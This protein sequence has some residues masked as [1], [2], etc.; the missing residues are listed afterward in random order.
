MDGLNRRAMENSGTHPAGRSGAWT[1]GVVAHG[2]DRRKVLNGVLWIFCEPERIMARLA[3]AIWTIPDRTPALPKLG[4]AR[5]HGASAADAGPTPQG[6]RRIGFERMFCGRDTRFVPAKRGSDKWGNT[7]RGKGARSWALQTAMVFLSPCGQ[8]ARSPAEVKLVAA[9]LEERIVAEVP[10]RLIG[11]KAYDSDRL[12]EQLMQEYGTEN[13]CTQ[14]S[15]PARVPTQDG[16]SLR[17]Y[18][19]RYKI[20][21]LFVRLFQ[22]PP[23]GGALRI[24]CGEFSRG[25]GPSG[26]GSY[27]PQAFTDASLVIFREKNRGLRD[28]ERN[29]S[30]NRATGF[31]C[32]PL[33]SSC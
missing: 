13:D 3:T 15:Q 29:N 33:R 30:R 20:E 25:L 28:E 4:R 22:L 2:A 16:R 23:T 32:H 24:S 21:R 19:R 7:K 26:C 27:T 11:D 18:V 8:K 10:E 12:D 1:M 5:G 6:R 31:R 14:Q 17:R 9:T